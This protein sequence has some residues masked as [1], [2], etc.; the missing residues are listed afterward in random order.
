MSTWSRLV[1]FQDASGD[2]H[3]GQP[4]DAKQDVGLAVA[5]GKTVEVYLIEGDLY[6]GTVTHTK[7]QVV[8]VGLNFL[9]VLGTLTVSDAYRSFSPQFHEMIAASFGA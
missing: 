3:L 1:R 8:K 9:L 7:A 6:T 5:E 2:V 4:V